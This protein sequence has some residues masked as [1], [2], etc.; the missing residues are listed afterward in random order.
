M[1]AGAAARERSSDRCVRSE[2]AEQLDVGG[3]RREQHLLDP[4]ILDALAV[5]GLDAE[6]SPIEGHGDLQVPDG[7]PHVVDIGEHHAVPF[8]CIEA[9]NS[10]AATT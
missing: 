6:Q 9:I 2:R 1:D 8:G 7:D 5:D 4:L 10:R 3:A